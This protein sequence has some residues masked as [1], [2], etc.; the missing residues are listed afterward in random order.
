[1]DVKCNGCGKHM[2]TI[3]D[4]KLRK[5][6]VMLCINCQDQK[7]DNTVTINADSSESFGQQF[8]NA[9]GLDPSDLN[10]MKFK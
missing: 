8:K 3:R 1:M 2:G 5:G 6:W 7:S 9:F 4:A 10:N